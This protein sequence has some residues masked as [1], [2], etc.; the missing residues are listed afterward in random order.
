MGPDVLK[1]C[2][3]KNS[4]AQRCVKILEVVGRKRRMLRLSHC[5]LAETREENSRY[6][7]MNLY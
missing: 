1:T 5:G 4:R 3:L 6:T 2:C 7:L